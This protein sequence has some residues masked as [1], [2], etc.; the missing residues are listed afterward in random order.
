MDN[1]KSILS[2]KK[3]VITQGKCNSI[4]EKYNYLSQ[5]YNLG[6][7]FIL[8]LRKDFGQNVVDNLFTYLADANINPD[9]NVSGLAYWYCK[10]YTKKSIQDKL[11]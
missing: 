6:V 10:K 3:I 7:Y 1:I 2:N 9:K 4:Y 5:K 8:R 11:F